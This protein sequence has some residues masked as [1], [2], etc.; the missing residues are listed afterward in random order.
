MGLFTFIK[1]A[2]AKL[3][4][5]KTST[6]IA[7]EDAAK[8]RETQLVA[9]INSFSL[10][11]AG[12]TATLN[13]S[14]VILEGKVKT[15]LEK[16]RIIVAAGNI[17]GIDGVDDRIELEEVVEIVPETQF[18]TVMKGDWLSKISKTVYGDANKYNVIFEAN[19]PMLTDPDKIY[20]GQVLV[21]PALTKV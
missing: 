12:V 16:N 1:D 20:P 9:H 2:G 17:E 19:K 18:Y 11:T 13:G 5:K 10:Q 14:T 6:E 8:E 21:I 3:F 4:N 7:A 15:M